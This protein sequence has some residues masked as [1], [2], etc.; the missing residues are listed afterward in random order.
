M[1]KRR[2]VRVEI[3][4]LFDAVTAAVEAADGPGGGAPRTGQKLPVRTGEKLPAKKE[5]RKNEDINPSRTAGRSAAPPP[6][7]RRL[8]ENEK[9]QDGAE[10]PSTQYV[11]QSSGAPLTEQKNKKSQ[12]AG[13]PRSAAAPPRP[14]QR[15]GC[16]PIPPAPRSKTTSSK[17]AALPQDLARARSLHQ[18]LAQHG[19]VARKQP[20]L[21]LWAREFAVLRQ[22]HGASDA[23]QDEALRWYGA[24]LLDPYVPQIAS[25][26]AFR[27][28]YHQLRA[29]MERSGDGG[30]GSVCEETVKIVE[31]LRAFRWPKDS[32]R[33]LPAAVKSSLDAVAAFAAALRG[34]DGPDRLRRA[35][36]NLAYEIGT[37][38]R[39]VEG[40]FERVNAR[41]NAWEDWSGDF[42][43][44]VWRVGHEDFRRWAR[45]MCGDYSHRPE[46][47]DEIR[48]LLPV[49]PAA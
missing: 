24:H 9:A 7:P 47:F 14:G 42:R 6:P 2:W 19:R 30:Q 5:E 35:A 22:Q 36:D 27:A 46:D 1:P 43:P 4:R 18:L 32:L 17:H 48:A 25:G 39:F 10:R 29:A 40:W 15:N 20:K 49:G 11:G 28:K 45:E 33:R 16:S 13:P 12:H 41:V 31:R 3:E 23:E 38:G 8:R 34:L 26:A 44:F 21:A 37:P